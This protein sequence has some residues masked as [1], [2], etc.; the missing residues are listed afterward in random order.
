MPLRTRIRVLSPGENDLSETIEEDDNEK[1]S[2]D[3]VKD[4]DAGCDSAMMPCCIHPALYAPSVQ[5][6]DYA[7]WI[8]MHTDQT[9][10]VPFF[11]SYL[12]PIPSVQRIIARP[13]HPPAAVKCHPFTP[14]EGDLNKASPVENAD[15]SAR[16]STDLSVVK[17]IEANARERTRVHTISAAFQK[18]RTLVPAASTGQRLSRLTILRIACDYIML[19]GAMNGLDYSADQKGV[20]IDEVRQRLLQL[21]HEES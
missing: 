4:V 19:L 10:M 15:P 9:W 3:V 8:R 16:C 13:A 17:R 18:L 7:Q 6:I 12:L 2:S 14:D 1:K 20:S 21:I 11:G 5:A